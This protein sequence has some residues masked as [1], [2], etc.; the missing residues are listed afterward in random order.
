MSPDVSRLE[1][2][3]AACIERNDDVGNKLISYKSDIINCKVTIRYHRNCRSTYTSSHHMKRVPKTHVPI[4]NPSSSTNSGD[5]PSRCY[6]RSC[7]AAT[8]D[9]KQN[10]FICGDVC[11]AKHRSTWSMVESAI[12]TKDPKKESMYTK[13]LNAAEK[14]QDKEMMARLH[15]VAN[16]DLVAIEAR[17]HRKKNCYTH[18][19][20]PKQIATQASR[21]ENV[22]VFNQKVHE[23]IKEFKPA[24]IENR[25]VFLLSTLRDDFHAMLRTA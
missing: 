13:V 23:L 15:G 5:G 17:Y 16:G 9:C 18:Y 1:S 19:I 11:S 25:E 7:V 6:T 12:S 3:F 10:C 14:H 22:S 21:T 20:D 2:L 4:S 24:I 8:F